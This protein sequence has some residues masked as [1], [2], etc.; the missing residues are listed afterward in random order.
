MRFNIL[1][2]ALDPLHMKDKKIVEQK[3][4]KCLMN[5]E[6]WGEIQVWGPKAEIVR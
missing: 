2:D 3:F 6:I 1:L 5:K 4:N